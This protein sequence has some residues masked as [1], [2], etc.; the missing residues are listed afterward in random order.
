[1][2]KNNEPTIDE[3]FLMAISRVDIQ[4]EGDAVK[5]Q[6]ICNIQYPSFT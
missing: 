2:A 6:Y 3:K 4:V 5:K 1:M